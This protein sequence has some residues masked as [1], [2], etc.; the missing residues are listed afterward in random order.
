M[1]ELSNRKD[2]IAKSISDGIDADSLGILLT[3]EQEITRNSNLIGVATL[4]THKAY[5][6][7]RNK[8]NVLIIE[9]RSVINI[10]KDGKQKVLKK[11]PELGIEI[12][13]TFVIS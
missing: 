11:L 1:E 2:L 4:A 7:S 6:S 12:P 3:G 9:G 13:D 10:S 8:S 5:L